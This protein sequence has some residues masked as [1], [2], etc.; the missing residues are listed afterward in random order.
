MY[1]GGDQHKNVLVSG[2]NENGYGDVGY[3][4]GDHANEASKMSE[5]GFDKE[6]F[7]AILAVV[8][9]WNFN[10]TTWSWIDTEIAI[11]VKPDRGPFTANEAFATQSSAVDPIFLSDLQDGEVWTPEDSITRG[12]LIAGW[13]VEN[14]V[15]A[16]SNLRVTVRRN[17]GMWSAD[18]LS[19]GTL[20]G[21]KT[22][23]VGDQ[24][25]WEWYGASPKHCGR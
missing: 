20:F 5:L 24:L 19:M 12:P 1:N 17:S 4:P 16:G 11:F 10:D 7:R 3:L 14:N 22:L 6:K 18:D 9:R 23:G 2:V 13:A 8:K 25:F 21:S 15:T